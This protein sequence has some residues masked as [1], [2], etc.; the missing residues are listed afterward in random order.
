MHYTRL[1][2]K[3]S[4]CIQKIHEIDQYIRINSID[5]TFASCALRCF[6]R[7]AIA[8]TVWLGGGFGMWTVAALKK[9]THGYKLN[10]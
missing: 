7:A 8:C 4:Q 3:T 5:Y 6:W 1:L 10:M 2:K 9:I